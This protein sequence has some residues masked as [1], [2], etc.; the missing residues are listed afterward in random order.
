MPRFPFNFIEGSFLALI[1]Q[2]WYFIM[3]PYVDEVLDNKPIEKSH[4]VVVKYLVEG[5]SLTITVLSCL[6]AY[7][8]YSRKHGL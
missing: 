2:L 3:N 4:R 6:M 1:P 7:Q 5:L 8:A